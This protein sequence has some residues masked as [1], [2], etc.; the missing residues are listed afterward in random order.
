MIQFEVLGTPAPK[1]SR[2]AVKNKWTGKAMTIPG[3]SKQNEANLKSWDVA[4]REAALAAVRSVGSQP[5]FI[6]CPVRVKILFVMRRPAGHFNK[7]GLK[8]TAPIYPIVK[9]DI[10]K[11]V[12]STIDS[13]TGIVFDDDARI[14]VLDVRKE[15]AMDA[16]EGAYISVVPAG[17]LE[18][19]HFLSRA[20]P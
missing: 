12:R 3:G 6:Q 20:G 16:A 4:V 17:T 10:D 8:L 9:P 5:A 13:M 7:K 1:G 18:E 14:A 15:Y 19:Y 2:R 11:L